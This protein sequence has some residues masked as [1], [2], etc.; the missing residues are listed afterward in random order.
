MTLSIEQNDIVGKTGEEHQ[1][2]VG[3]EFPRSCVSK[4]S[5]SKQVYRNITYQIRCSQ[6]KYPDRLKIGPIRVFVNTTPFLSH[7][8]MTLSIETPLRNIQFRRQCFCFIF[9]SFKSSNSSI[10]SGEKFHSHTKCAH[11]WMEFFCAI[12]LN[13][14]SKLL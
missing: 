9:L 1:N 8:R 11:R 2:E 14:R 7:Y 12:S 6:I 5:E 4:N 3:W 13:F 10:P